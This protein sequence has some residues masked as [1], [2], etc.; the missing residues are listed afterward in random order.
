MN[1]AQDDFSPRELGRKLGHT[2]AELAPM[3]TQSRSAAETDVAR[4]AESGSVPEDVRRLALGG[5][6]E[7]LSGRADERAFLDGFVQGV[8]AFVAG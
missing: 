3:R 2:W 1:E 4:V 5:L 7:R 6:S 8:R